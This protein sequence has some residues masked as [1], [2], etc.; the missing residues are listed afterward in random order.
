MV[1]NRAGR[2]F[3][4]TRQLCMSFPG[5]SL[6]PFPALLCQPRDVDVA[7]VAAVPAALPALL[8]SARSCPY[9]PREARRPQT[10]RPS[11]VIPD[12]RTS[13][14][15]RTGLSGPTLTPSR[16]RTKQKLQAP[17]LRNSNSLARPVGP[18]VHSS[19]LAVSRS[20]WPPSPLLQQAGTVCGPPLQQEGGL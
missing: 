6:L 12:P 20:R 17:W 13:S 16:H 7:E 15:L 8:Q 14:H 4:F 2:F 11:L 9:L 18:N 19:P 3:I 5:L 10:L 1:L